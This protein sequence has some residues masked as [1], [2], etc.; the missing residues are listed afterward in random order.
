V[1]TKRKPTFRLIYFRRLVVL[2]IAFTGVA[3]RHEAAADAVIP[4]YPDDARYAFDPRE[5]A[6]LPEYCKYTQLFRNRVQGGNDPKRIE[7]WH[8]TLGE[9][10]L[11]LHHYCWG[12]MDTNRALFL[13]RSKQVATH[14]L[15]TSV[16][17]FDYVLERAPA[18]FPLSPEILTKKGENLIRLGR[19]PSGVL[20]L[21]RAIELKPDYWPPY[22]A[23]SDYYSE[24]GNPASAREILQKG[25][26][27]SPNA[28]ALMSRLARLDTNKKA[29]TRHAPTRD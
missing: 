27:V 3:M 10:F 26:A 23:L 29:A 19:G 16:S 7:Q 20:E 14:Y 9:T 24:L 6:L 22:A 11:A 8:A 18:D 17:E 1:T 5:V 2:A 21:Q 15:N 12:L 28:K 25:L 13:A 4:G